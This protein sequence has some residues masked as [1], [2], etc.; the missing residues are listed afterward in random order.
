LPLAVSSAV[1]F[2]RR[3]L[4]WSQSSVQWLLSSSFAFLQ[5]L[6]Q[7]ILA[8]RPQP[9]GSSHGLSFPSALQGPKVHSPRVLPARYVPPSGFGYP[10]DGL[11]PS[12]P[13]RFCFTPAALLGFTLRSFPL[14]KG[15][16]HVTARKHPL[17]VFPLG[18]AARRDERPARRPR[19]LGFNPFESP[20]PPRTCLAYRP[21]AAPLGFAPSRAIHQKP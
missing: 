4:R 14:S 20:W 15:I 13:C 19:F 6:L 10:L 3:G 18:E 21:L 1:W 9:S 7:R 11:L 5:S 17:T 2:S 12:N 16:R 8:S